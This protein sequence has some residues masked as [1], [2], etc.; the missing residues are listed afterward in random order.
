MADDSGR[1]RAS[2]A[3]NST[4]TL[5]LL[6]RQIRD[7]ERARILLLQQSALPPDDDPAFLHVVSE[8]RSMRQMVDEI[9][10]DLKSK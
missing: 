10:S 8:M 9:Q 2:A 7:L 1:S 3:W 6:R 4:V 5:S